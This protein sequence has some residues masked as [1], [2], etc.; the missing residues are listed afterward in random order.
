MRLK[1]FAVLFV[2][3]L[4]PFFISAQGVWTWV[5]GD[6]TAHTQHPY[7]ANY[8]V[9]GVPSP[10][11]EP[12][13]RYACT[14]WTD[15]SGRFWIYGAV[16]GS[17]TDLWMF[18]P[19]TTN[20]T[21][22]LGDSTGGAGTITGA[23]GVFTASN[24]PGSVSTG[25]IGWVTPDSHLWLSDNY[26]NLWQYDPAVNEWA[27]MGAL[28]PVNYGTKGV[29]N[30]STLP[31]DRVETSAAWADS[32]GNLWF[33]GGDYGSGSYNDMWEYNVST[34]IWTW[35]SGTNVADDAGTYGTMGVGSV[36]NIPPGRSVN[37]IWKDSS[38]N[39]WLTGGHDIT[40]GNH[41]QDVWKFNPQTLEWTWV[42]GTQGPDNSAPV[43]AVG[44]AAPGNKEGA[45]Y[46]N[47]AV[48]KANENLIVNHSGESSS[49]VNTADNDLW[50]YIPSLQQWELLGVGPLSGSYGTKGVASPANFPAARVGAVGF[51]DK[52]GDLWL[53]G[54]NLY[55]GPFGNDLWEYT[56]PITNLQANITPLNAGCSGT[57][58]GAA[59]VTAS[60]GTPP[61][62]YLWQPGND[63][64]ANISNLCAG[65]YNVTVT[66]AA[67]DTVTQ[68]ATITA[69]APP[70]VT[71]ASADTLICAGDSTQ[72][73]ATGGF[74]T[75]SW[76]DGNTTSCIYAFSAGNYYVS[77]SDNNN[78]TAVSNHISISAYPSPSLSISVSG[79]TLT[80]YDAEAYQ[81]LL[82][83][84]A[85]SGAT[86]SVL[87]APESGMYSVTVR[88]TNGC[89]ATSNPQTITVNGV[90]DLTIDDEV[91][92]YPNPL[93]S[94]SWRLA[95]SDRLI[96]AVVEIFDN[97]GR[98]VFS[99]RITGSITVM[100]PEVADGV[101]LMRITSGYGNIIRKL[102]KI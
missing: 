29:G 66:D 21:F 49:G 79:D 92:V 35:M 101:Y 52:S 98:M 10:L 59:S 57:C 46:E 17:S 73:C 13:G 8:G 3:S 31:G 84:Q 68:S 2:V 95:V 30:T 37:M 51:V 87:I 85:L 14:H 50:A 89:Y 4:A 41:F 70:Q 47:R 82:N 40:S 83:G 64:S 16:N 78:C 19:A 7:G 80:A 77:V 76:N 26:S 71:V 33:F 39:F 60:S 91:S 25:K 12:A 9:M 54:G 96:G 67:G 6:S 22:M 34:G 75:Y 32:S 62:H 42:S 90:N 93:Q 97:E 61:Y 55:T 15:T 23:K 86:D 88:D 5:K 43:G 72:I 65:T 63:T 44:V 53:F 24:N 18:D 94:G 1:D 81:W 56:F 102:V 20:W 58:N 11:N 45:C 74:V 99:S 27:W 69:S 48:W 38:G 36:N 100:N 28:G